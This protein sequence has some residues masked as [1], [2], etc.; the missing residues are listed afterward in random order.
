MLDQALSIVVWNLCAT[1]DTLIMQKRNNLSID[2]KF[3]SVFDL[4]DRLKSIKAS[5]YDPA[6]MFQMKA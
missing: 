2:T 5:T 6:F 3:N 1:A 4:Y